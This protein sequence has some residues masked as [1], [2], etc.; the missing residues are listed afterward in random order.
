MKQVPNHS[1]PGNACALA[2]YTMIAQYLLPGRNITFKQLA[3][4]TD[5]KKGM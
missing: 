3:K 5:W 1:N 2:C 4:I